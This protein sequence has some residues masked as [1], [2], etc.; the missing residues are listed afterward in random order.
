MKLEVFLHPRNISIVEVLYICIRRSSMIEGG[1]SDTERSRLLGCQNSIPLRRSL[2]NLLIDPVHQATKRKNEPIQFDNKTTLSLCLC[3][4]AP[5]SDSKFLKKAHIGKK[6]LKILIFALLKKIQADY[7]SL[8]VS[9]SG[10]KLWSPKSSAITIPS[11]P[12]SHFGRGQ[13][14]P[15]MLAHGNNA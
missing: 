8:Y 12:G 11:S 9:H 5:H 14:T 4:M 2:C 13:C 6:E 15:I 3:R 10:T 7:I 1:T